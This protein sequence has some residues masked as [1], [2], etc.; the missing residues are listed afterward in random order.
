MFIHTRTNQGLNYVSIVDYYS[1][2]SANYCDTTEG[3][4]KCSAATE[5]CTTPMI[6]SKDEACEGRHTKPLFRSSN[7]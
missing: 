4:C 6:C 7:K 3:S 5:K 1:A 2:N